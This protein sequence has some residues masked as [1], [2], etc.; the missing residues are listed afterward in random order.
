MSNTET[1]VAAIEQHVALSPTIRDAFLKV[2]RHLFVPQY[3][4][5]RGKEWILQDANAD[6]VY[7]DR[8]LVT[9]VDQGMSTSSSSAPSVMG[10]MLEALDLHH[11]M[12][13]LEI[14]AGTGYNAALIASL[15]GESGRVVSVDIDETLVAT[16]RAHLQEAGFDQVQVVFTDGVHA[17]EPC[18]P[19]DRIIVTAGF[20]KVMHAW[21]EQ[22]V[23]G[24][25]LVGNLLGDL[26]SV[27]VRLVKQEDGSLHGTI[28]P[29]AGFFMELRGAKY[30]VTP[31]D[32]SHYDAVPAE[33]QGISFDLPMLLKEQAFLFYLQ[34]VIPSAKLHMRYNGGP[35]DHPDSYEQWLID[36]KH[37]TCLL[38][39]PTSSPDEWVI[40]ARGPLW[41]QVIDAYRQWKM[42]EE[43][44]LTAYCLEIAPSGV[45]SVILHDKRWVVAN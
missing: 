2:N 22:L 8:S 10:V 14:G 24:G 27:L 7:Q 1:L 39:R 11:G 29:Q 15:V 43:P 42:L 5:H 37:P 20:R 36:E 6:I 40:H 16:A 13:A 25:I 18:A 32:W 12:C 31:F 26:F 44:A 4:A 21:R 3:Y 30:L 19:Y 38:A 9:Q 23:P 17:Y 45:Q 35:L 41:H 33:E 34:A 28:L